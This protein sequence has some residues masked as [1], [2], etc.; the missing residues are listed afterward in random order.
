LAACTTG[1]R[2]KTQLMLS[3]GN[4]KERR[5]RGQRGE[6]KGFGTKNAVRKKS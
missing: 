3:T 2:I 6:K 4:F 1:K 5:A